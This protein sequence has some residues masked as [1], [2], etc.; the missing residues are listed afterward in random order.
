[1]NLEVKEIRTH[2]RRLTRKINTLKKKIEPLKEQKR[3]L[4]KLLPKTIPEARGE[5]VE[6]KEEVKGDASG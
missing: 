6:I 3:E 4:W 1:M 2:L 5:S